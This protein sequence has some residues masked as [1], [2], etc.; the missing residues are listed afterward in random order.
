MRFYFA[1]ALPLLSYLT[2]S[3]AAPTPSNLAN[4][5]AYEA[6][7]L[8]SEF[9]AREFEDA[10]ERRGVPYTPRPP[11]KPKVNHA[12]QQTRK[13]AV[14]ARVSS[15]QAANAVKKT[16]LK[17]QHAALGPDHRYG[18]PRAPKKAPKV[19]LSKKGKPLTPPGHR[20][21]SRA[22]GHRLPK[23]P[24]TPKPNAVKGAPKTAKH[25][26]S[27]KEALARKHARVAAG[28]ANFKHAAEQQKKTDNLPNRKAT[29]TTTG[30]KKYTGK[31]VRTAVFNG[32]HFESNPV[33]YKPT[34][35]RNDEQGPAGAK[36]RPLPHMTGAGREFPVSNARGGYQGTGDVGS[37]RAITQHNPATGRHTYMGVIAH[38][39]TR[40]KT[41]PGYNDHFEVKPVMPPPKP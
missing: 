33:N 4:W 29:F 9:E 30:G 19:E 2:S 13:A 15:N 35:F 23:Q 27:Q 11:K 6:R 12:A 36:T 25:I 7:S 1:L 22:A 37:A 21:A 38:D 10:L 14:K 34:G 26:N 41:H 31:D 24:K 40:D 17:A 8:A 39:E 3:L 20:A 28:R 16:N 18:K 5:E 32:H